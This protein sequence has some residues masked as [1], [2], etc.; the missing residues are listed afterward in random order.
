MTLSDWAKNDWLKPHRTSK[1]EIAGLFSI[2]ER[3]L[4]DAQ[5]EG[6]SPDGRFTHAYRASLTL[7]TILLYIS[8][9]MPARGQSHHYRTILALPKIMGD[10]ATDDA[11]YLDK[12][13]VK[14]NAAEYDS[15]NEASEGEA[16]E[17]VE[18]SEE[19]ERTVR[20]W[21]SKESVGS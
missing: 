20:D 21:V 14:R 8:G 18:F 2:V 1:Q 10:G 15:A 5:L 11:E 17:L 3:E 16:K 12:C 6:I 9:Y 19:F 13:R 7:A 4:R